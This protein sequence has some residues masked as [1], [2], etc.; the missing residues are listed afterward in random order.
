MGFCPPFFVKLKKGP[1]NPKKTTLDTAIFKMPWSQALYGLN[2]PI[3]TL[4]R[5]K[6]CSIIN[7]ATESS[8]AGLMKLHSQ[9]LQD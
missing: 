8:T 4:Y 6:L 7:E 5:V 2:E 3:Y 9:A 1:A